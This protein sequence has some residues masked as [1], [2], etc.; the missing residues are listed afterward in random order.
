MV[1]P[2]VTCS[3]YWHKAS[4]FGMELVVENTPSFAVLYTDEDCSNN[5]EDLQSTISHHIYS[6]CI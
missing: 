3:D 5:A 4:A 2:I 6:L 1:Q